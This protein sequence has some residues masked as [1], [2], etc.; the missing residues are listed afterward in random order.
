MAYISV[1]ITHTYYK[2]HFFHDK[3][4]LWAA[5]MYY[6]NTCLSDLCLLIHGCCTTF[7]LCGLV[8]HMVHF[9]DHQSAHPCWRAIILVVSLHLYSLTCCVLTVTVRGSG[10]DHLIGLLLQTT[11]CCWMPPWLLYLPPPLVLVAVHL[12]I[13]HFTFLKLPHSPVCPVA[14]LHSTRA[15][16]GSSAGFLFFLIRV[17]RA[18]LLWQL[19]D[20]SCWMCSALSST[21]TH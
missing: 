21:H 18:N 9:S 16:T 2:L 1:I 3:D 8:S 11:S 6:I 19:P 12:K 10:V 15:H 7:F 17:L 13:F 20:S 5:S 4:R 14:L